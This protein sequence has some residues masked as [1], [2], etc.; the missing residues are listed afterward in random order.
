MKIMDSGNLSQLLV[1]NQMNNMELNVNLVDSALLKV[2][3]LIRQQFY[4]WLQTFKTIQMIFQR[5]L[6]N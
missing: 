4:V 3:I 2:H 1:N 6:F 5:K